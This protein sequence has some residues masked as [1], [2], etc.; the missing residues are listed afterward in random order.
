MIIQHDVVIVGAGIAGLRAAI[1]AALAGGDAAASR[2]YR[3]SAAN[4]EG[5][6]ALMYDI[7]NYLEEQAQLAAEENTEVGKD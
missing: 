3:I 1:E 5:T 4:R 7:L 6:E 2:V